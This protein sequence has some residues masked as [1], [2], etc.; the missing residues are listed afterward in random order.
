[1][2]MILT[3]KVKITPTEEQQTLLQ[4]T[5]QTYRKGCNYVSGVIYTTKNLVQ[6]SL[7][8]ATYRPLREKL[9]LRSQMA[10]SV[11]KTTIARYKST[12]ENGHEWTKVT[13]KKAELDLVW[14]RDYSLVQGVFSVNTLAGRIKERAARDGR[15][16]QTGAAIQIPASK[17]PGFKAGKQLKDKVG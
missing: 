10:Q 2:K 5:I 3:A 9:G 11:M 13:F 17:A 1:M 16:P 7:H 15:N 12:M 6:A 14:N 8:T 4:E